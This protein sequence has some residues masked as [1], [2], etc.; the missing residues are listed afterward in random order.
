MSEYNYIYLKKVLGFFIS[1]VS[2]IF[3]AIPLLLLSLFLLIYYRGNPFYIGKRAGI[4]GQVFNQYKFR[5]MYDCDSESG[6]IQRVSFVGSFLRKWSIDELPQL[7]NVVKGDMS[8]IGPR[9]LTA[10]YIKYYTDFEKRRLEVKPG[11]T[12]YAQVNGRN[13]LTWEEKFRL[14]V[15]YVDNLSWKLDLKI[16]FA[17]FKVVLTKE[18]I[19]QTS[20]VTS[21]RFIR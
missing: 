13:N 4:D 8:L 7:L 19:N 3:L 10:E 15:H 2:L 5:S 21:T 16:L 14:D 9:P 12:G 18:G 20:E 1:C 6:E 11:L 17:T